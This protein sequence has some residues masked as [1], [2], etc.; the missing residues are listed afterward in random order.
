MAIRGPKPKPTAQKKARGVT[1]KDRLNENEPTPEAATPQ[2]P[3][4]LGPL[5]KQEWARLIGELTELGM[6]TNLDRAGLAAYCIAYE[7]MVT[8][9]AAI[10]AYYKAHGTLLI[11]T[12]K[13]GLIQHPGIGI[14]NRASEIMDR[15][16]GSLGLNPSSRTRIQVPKKQ[17]DSRWSAFGGP[18]PPAGPP[19]ATPGIRR[20]K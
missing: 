12:E 20:V 4:E 5:A 1:R 2:C 9:E 3:K 16:S 11:E 7:R 18:K 17:K 15:F 19:K 6:M 13:G 14:V 8:T 10:Q